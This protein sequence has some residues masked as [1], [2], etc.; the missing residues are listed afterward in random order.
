L[1]ICTVITPSVAVDTIKK[2]STP[3]SKGDTLFVGG[4]G[5]GNYTRIQDAIDNSSDGDTVFVYDDSSPYFENVIVD[6]SINLIGEDMNTTIIDS[7]FNGTVVCIS[8]EGVLISGFMIQN[9][10]SSFGFAGIDIE[11]NNI[12][13]N[14]NRI[15]SNCYGITSLGYD[16]NNIISNIICDNRFGIYFMY[17]SN[18]NII[19]NNTINSNYLGIYI[20]DS[21]IKNSNNN[22]IS[23]NII[24]LNK[25]KGINLNDCYSISI[26]DNEINN[27]TE[28]GIYLWGCEK[29]TISNNLIYYNKGNGISIEGGILNTIT[30]NTINF[31]NYYG[32]KLAYY[33][34][35]PHSN[36][37]NT[38]FNRIKRNNI[39]NNVVGIRHIGLSG[40]KNTFN[41][42][43]SNNLINNT[44]NAMDNCKDFWDN[45]KYGNYW[46]DYQDQYP[47]AKPKSYK[48]W[49]WDTPYEI[50]DGE[51]KDKCPLINQR[52]KSKPRTKISNNP[53]N[54]NLLDRL[55]N[56][57]PLLE[58]FLRA[59]NLL[60]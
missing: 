23:N 22:I 54:F 57:Y 39:S 49:I 8:C 4:T 36:E 42:I 47:Y 51:N 3:I 26:I 27:N 2:P 43:I 53:P 34:P 44:R 20:Q 19:K 15:S 21:T 56:R 59:M 17:N 6:K 45:G 16:N 5:E 60:R 13:I 30:D 25:E 55:F 14:G 11:A 33:T 1:F 58:V 46:S 28:E 40:N 50:T 35:N 29:N 10:S 24:M 52:P 18:F 12:N 31:N 48:P 7:N 32:I 9:S 38:K 41:V 37:E